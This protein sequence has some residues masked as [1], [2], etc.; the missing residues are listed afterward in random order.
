[1]KNKYTK[2][3]IF[4]TIILALAGTSYLWAAQQ[5]SLWPLNDNEPSADL[6]SQGSSE[7]RQHTRKKADMS[8][9][10]DPSPE[11]VVSNEGGKSTVGVI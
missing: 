1:M 4:G 9:G 10:S 11:P 8:T 5:Y 2:T 3:L 6:D 7:P